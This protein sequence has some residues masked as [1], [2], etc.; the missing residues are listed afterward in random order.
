[1]GER[2]AHGA[3][4]LGKRGGAVRPVAPRIRH[5]FDRDLR[6]SSPSRPI[7][8]S[9]R[10]RSVTRFSRGSQ[11]TLSGNSWSS[12]RGLVPTRMEAPNPASR[13]EIRRRRSAAWARVSGLDVHRR[14]TGHGPAWAMDAA[15]D[16]VVVWDASS[17]TEIGTG[18][19]ARRY[20]APDARGG[21]VSGEHLH[22]GYQGYPAVAMNASGEFVVVWRSGLPGRLWGRHRAV[23][24]TAA[25]H[26]GPPPR[27]GFHRHSGTAHSADCP[28][29][30]D[31]SGEFV[32][33]WIDSPVLTAGTIDV[34][35]RRFDGTGRRREATFR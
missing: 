5:F 28:R 17:R 30:A 15:G 25:A 4:V 14:R 18:V 10:T 12:G 8:R 13:A 3:S 35:A 26:R 6:R 24:S 1:M 34:F 19:L 29:S 32:V 33:A 20:E 11:L 21:R 31:A 7:F 16:F 2:P 22:T 27:R 23:S 9:T